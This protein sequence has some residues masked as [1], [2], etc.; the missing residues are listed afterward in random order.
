MARYNYIFSN[1]RPQH[2]GQYRGMIYVPE[3]GETY[4]NISEASKALGVDASNISKV[5]KGSRRTAGGYHFEKTTEED[6]KRRKILKQ[7]REEIRKAN[8]I[9]KKARKD[10][11]EN[12]VDEVADLDDFGGDVIGST[13]DNLIDD[14][15]ETLEDM[16]SDE[17]EQLDKKLKENIEA[18]EKGLEKANDRLQE[19]ADLFGISSPEMAKYEPLIPDINRTLD[20]A[21]D[22]NGLGSDVYEFIRDQ[23]QNNVDPD[24]LRDLLDK[25]NNY[26]DNPERG[27]SLYDILDAWQY[28]EYKGQSWEDIMNEKN[29]RGWK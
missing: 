7:V 22:K 26:L 3:T 15:S 6:N 12:F 29:G 27:K 2:G 20:R 10:Q 21:R 1:D 28:R 5:I 19:Y 18:A 17:L 23:I 16:E 11:R 9:I 14:S 8:N 13:Q 4:R 24:E 25:I